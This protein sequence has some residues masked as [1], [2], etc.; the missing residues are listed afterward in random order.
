MV[1]RLQD[2]AEGESFVLPVWVKSKRLCESK[3]GR[4][5][6][7][8]RLVDKSGECEARIWDNVE[9]TDRQFA[10]SDFVEVAGKMVRHQGALQAHLT[11]VRKLE[12]AIDYARFL[13]ASR[14]DAEG[15]YTELLSLIKAEVSNADVRRLLLAI[16]EDADIARRY[17]YA[18]AARTHHHAYLSGL[19]EHSLGLAKLGLTVLPHYPKIDKSTVIAGLLLHDIGKIYELSYMDGFNYTDAGKLV[20][21]LVMGVELLTAKARELSAFPEETLLLLKHTIV[22][23]HGQIEFGSPVLPQTLEA[24]MVHFLDN[25]DSKLAAMQEL[26]E[27]EQDGNGN[28]TAFNPMYGRTMYKTAPF[29]KAPDTAPAHTEP[30]NKQALTDKKSEPPR[31]SSPRGPLSSS[32]AEKFAGLKSDH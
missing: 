23:H 4:P 29:Q 15:M 9:A 21:H 26:L 7:S 13:P 27:K 6:L 12:G 28:W 2:L 8:A 19:L 3:T 32:L 30:I 18:P 31:P 20:G 10:A 25:M 24:I 22:G 1:D 14:R 11:E 16:F 5:Y 17:K